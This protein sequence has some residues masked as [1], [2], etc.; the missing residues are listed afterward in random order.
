LGGPP[1][2]GGLSLLGDYQEPCQLVS[3]PHYTPSKILSR[4]K[5]AWGQV[6]L[7]G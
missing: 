2:T 6:G 4:P 5:Q 3:H 7:W 1:Y